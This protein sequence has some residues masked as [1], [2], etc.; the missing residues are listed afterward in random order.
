[1]WGEDAVVSERSRIDTWVAARADEFLGLEGQDVSGWWGVEVAF[2][3]GEDG[4]PAVFSD[5]RA[6][7]LQL[8]TLGA[9]L[10]AATPIVVANY[11]NDYGFGLLVRPPT[12]A[13]D[14]PPQD[15][16]DAPDGIYRYRQLTELPVGTTADVR[17][18]LS[19]VGDISSVSFTVSGA[20]VLLVAGEVRERAFRGLEFVLD[21]ESILAFTD[22]AAVNS[23]PWINPDSI[24]SP[25]PYNRPTRT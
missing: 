25:H 21:D 3:G 2:L 22:P 7:F 14:Q 17:V 16:T 13:C 6:P 1:V 24:R 20:P 12:W 18:N 15:E 5:E 10:G 23:V 4:W 9:T 8:A 19:A 11:Q